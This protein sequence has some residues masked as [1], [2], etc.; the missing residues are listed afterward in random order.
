MSVFESFTKERPLVLVG[1]G[2]MGGA[3]LAGWLERGLSPDALWVVE[4]AAA[5]IADRFPV[6]SRSTLVETAAHLPESLA[7]AAL[8]LAVKPQAMDQALAP[9]ADR[10]EPYDL[11][12]SIAAGK[13]IGYFEG[14]LGT[15]C[16][17]VRAMPNTPAAIGKG[18]TVGVANAAVGAKGREIAGALLSSVG[19]FAWVEDEDLMD[20]V[21]AVSGSG[22]AYVFYLAECLARAGEAAGLSAALAHMLAVNT[23]SGAGALLEESGEDP[24]TLRENVTSPGGTTA[25]ALEVL[26]GK[27]GLA[28]ILAEAVAAAARRSREL[29][30]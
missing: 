29:N 19:A 24:A 5:A 23:V 15:G 7:P 16:P 11:V 21:T 18:M 3:L 9:F 12:L 14:R 17:V 20:A 28:E 25:A 2:R 6:L 30:G 13:S 4:P 22:P 26:M 10:A 1:C 27:D 8:V